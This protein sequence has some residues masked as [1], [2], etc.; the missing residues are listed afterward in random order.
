MLS[1]VI[2]SEHSYPALPLAGSTGKP[3][4]RSFRSSRTKKDSS[5]AT[6]PTADRDQPVSRILVTYY[7]VYGLY[8]HPPKFSKKTYAETDV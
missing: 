5:Q 2:P 3:E 7:Y 4:V 1:A 6:A 8:L